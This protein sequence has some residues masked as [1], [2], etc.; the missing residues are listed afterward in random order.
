MTTL[1]TA[2]KETNVSLVVKKTRLSLFSRKQGL[3]CYILLRAKQKNKL[4]TLTIKVRFSRL[5]PFP[6]N[7]SAF[8]E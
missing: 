8:D 7:G 2:A 4:Q 3:S 1:L 6:A 5:L